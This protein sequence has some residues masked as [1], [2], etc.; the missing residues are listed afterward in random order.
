MTFTITIGMWQVIVV[1]IS[2]FFSMFGHH[3][4]TIINYNTLK[5]CSISTIKWFV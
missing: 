3:V 1:S 2:A 5:I 4:L